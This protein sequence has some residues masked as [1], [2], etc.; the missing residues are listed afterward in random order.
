MLIGKHLFSLLEN[1]SLVKMI[2]KKSL[3][4][5]YKLPQIKILIYGI[6]GNWLW[7][8]VHCPELLP[9]DETKHQLAP[10]WPAPVVQQYFMCL[11]L[12][13]HLPD[14]WQNTAILQGRVLQRTYQ[15]SSGKLGK[16]RRFLEG[17]IHRFRV[18]V[19]GPHYQILKKSNLK[20]DIMF[21]PLACA[22]MI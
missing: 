15:E 9:S 4:K 21:D 16:M 7:I 17:G 10:V 22:T 1:S 5:N 14:G 12:Q 11:D 20:T 18:E 6:L 8:L 3:S 19:R 13:V 2:L